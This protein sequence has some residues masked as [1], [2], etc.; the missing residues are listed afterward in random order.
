M[1]MPATLSLQLRRR[2][3]T[4]PDG[5]ATWRTKTQSGSWPAEKTALVLCD[6]WN[7]HTCRGAE[8]RLERMIPTMARLVTRLRDQGALIIHAPSDTMPNYEG[9]AARTRAQSANQDGLPPKVLES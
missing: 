2:T 5:F 4:H 8:V 6:V 9:I 3:L 7:H 1:P